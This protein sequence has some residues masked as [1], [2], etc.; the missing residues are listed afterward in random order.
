M[1]STFAGE[2]PIPWKL[3]ESDMNILSRSVG[4]HRHDIQGFANIS[5][6]VWQNCAEASA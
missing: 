6:N 2:S 5:Y 3:L 1:N 4:A